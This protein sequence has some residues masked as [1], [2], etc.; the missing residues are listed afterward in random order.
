M[1]VRFTSSSSQYM[2]YSG[3]MG[4]FAADE[5]TFAGWAA[6]VGSGQSQA[7][8]GMG[9][10][11][12]SNQYFYV[13]LNTLNQI[14]GVVRDGGT[15]QSAGGGT[16]NGATHFAGSFYDLISNDCDVRRYLNGT[17]GGRTTTAD[18][19][20]LTLTRFGSYANSSSGNYADSTLWEWAA[21]TPR[22]TDAEVLK[23]SQ[24]MHPL[25]MREET[26]LGYWP[27][28]DHHTAGDEFFGRY[29]MTVTNGPLTTPEVDHF[30]NGAL[31]Y[32]PKRSYFFLRQKLPPFHENQVRPLM[33]LPATA[34]APP[35][36]PPYVSALSLSGVGT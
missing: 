11:G 13:G 30:S 20:T 18:P 3:D 36:G 28:V 10:G 29:N 16:G 19:A 32:V 2:T 26:M 34:G 31:R 33:L 6:R 25:N 23:L 27:M 24:G 4:V 35:A 1:P 21:W 8:A 22:L 9:N 14:N 12:T 5:V 15:F 7:Y 17:G